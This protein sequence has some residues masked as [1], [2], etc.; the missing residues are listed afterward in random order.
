MTVVLIVPVVP[1]VPIVFNTRDRFARAALPTGIFARFALVC[2][3]AAD[4]GAYALVI[5]VARRTRQ[6]EAW[7]FCGVGAR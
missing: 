4:V 6:R 5:G 1:V 7:D 2:G 3:V